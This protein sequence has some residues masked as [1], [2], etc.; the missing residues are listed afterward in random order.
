MMSLNS[1]INFV[2]IYIVK[3]T[4]LKTN[5][6][7][8]QKFANVNISFRRYSKITMLKMY[9]ISSWLT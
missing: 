7:R 4:A 2:N 5:Y 8:L 1:K 3:S 9:R 6:P